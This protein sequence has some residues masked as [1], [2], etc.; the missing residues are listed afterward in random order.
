MLMDLVGAERIVSGTDYPQGMGVI[1]PIEYVEK[2]P[3]ITQKEA[4]LILCDNP[5]RLLRLSQEA[6]PSA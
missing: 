6:T 5:A 1:D 4:E 3:N 2:I